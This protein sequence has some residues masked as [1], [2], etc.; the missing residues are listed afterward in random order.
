MKSRNS[1]DQSD[2]KMK[3]LD[4]C[5]FQ[6]CVLWITVE[7]AKA[8]IGKCFL[9]LHN[10]VRKKHFKN[11]FVGSMTPVSTVWTDIEPINQM[12]FGFLVLHLI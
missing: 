9:H 3:S 10:S 2:F 4:L 8:E 5:W 11:I 7:I 1:F 6:I 12:W